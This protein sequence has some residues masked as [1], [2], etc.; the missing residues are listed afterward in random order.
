MGDGFWIPPAISMVILGWE[1]G[2]TPLAPSANQ[3]LRLAAAGFNPHIRQIALSPAGQSESIL[4]HSAAVFNPRYAASGVK[5]ADQSESIFRT[6]GLSST[7]SPCNELFNA[8][9]DISN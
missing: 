2:L 9:Q 3:I 5:P 8:H 1:G 4:R 6:A 7:I